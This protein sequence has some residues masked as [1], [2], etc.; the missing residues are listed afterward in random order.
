MNRKYYTGL[1]IV[2]S[3]L[4]LT[5][6]YY[7]VLRQYSDDAST[8]L[9]Y[10][11][12]SDIQEFIGGTVEDRKAYL[13]YLNHSD[14]IVGNSMTRNFFGWKLKDSATGTGLEVDVKQTLSKAGVGPLQSK[15][16]FYFGL[17]SVDNVDRILVDEQHE[18]KLIALDS[19]LP[20]LSENK[21]LWYVYFNDDLMED[22]YKVEVFNKENEVVYSSSY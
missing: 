18:A 3:L 12:V 19:Q 10:S 17:V 2:S 21:F 16:K 7:H 6:L 22:S 4:L 8:A 1:I 15:H 13:F 20:D 11:R 9:V 5:S 14:Q